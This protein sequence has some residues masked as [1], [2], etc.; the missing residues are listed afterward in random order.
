M[1][2][3]HIAI[4]NYCMALQADSYHVRLVNFSTEVAIPVD[5]SAEQLARRE[6][7]NYLRGRNAE[8][9]NVYARPTGYQYVL[10]DDLRRDS[11]AD[12]ALLCPCILIETSPVNY[13]VWLTLP[14]IPPHRDGAKAICRELAGRFGADLASADPDHVGRLPG[15]TN[16]K[17]KYRM[18]NGLFPFVKLHRF[19]NRSSTFH[20]C[21][22]AVYYSMN[23]KNS[24]T[25]QTDAPPKNSSSE[26]DFAKAC[27]LI[28]NGKSDEDIY[29]YLM[30]N[31]PNL[32]ERKGNRHVGNY[33]ERTIKNARLRV[34][35]WI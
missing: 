23:E 18:S 6:T 20:P 34:E 32:L 5:Y 9:Y 33:L 8:G 10:L 11:L 35:K 30:V 27:W 4:V 1:N 12:V 16:R 25:I 31:S 21:G 3:T 13:Q 26:W 22:G 24:P 17:E 28:H 14:D 15:F 19:E 29:Q 7:V 2:L